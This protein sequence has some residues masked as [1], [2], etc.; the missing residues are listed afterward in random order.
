MT[1]LCGLI[2]GMLMSCSIPTDLATC[3][4]LTAY[5]KRAM[6]KLAQHTCLVVMPRWNEIAMCN[7]HAAALM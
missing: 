2:H 4:I 5:L 3:C 7:T 1:Q 6:H